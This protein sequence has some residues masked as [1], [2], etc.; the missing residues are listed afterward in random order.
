MVIIPLPSAKLKEF[1]LKVY[2]K[3][4]VLSERFSRETKNNLQIT[5]FQ[6]KCSSFI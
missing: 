6:K 2:L 4:F 1:K 3:S 5:P